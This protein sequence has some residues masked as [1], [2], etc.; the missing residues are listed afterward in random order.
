MLMGRWE[1]I[2]EQSAIAVINAIT[3]ALVG[4]I[5][6]GILQSFIG[7][8]KLD[9][10]SSMLRQEMIDKHNESIRREGE[11][12]A[13]IAELQQ[14]VQARPVQ[15]PQHETKKMEPLEPTVEMPNPAQQRLDFEN[16]HR[17]MYSTANKE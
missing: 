15:P 14:T 6:Y 4:L 17:L 5:G 12:L 1:W 10:M 2:K 16:R 9:R 7:D 3:I 13:K 8:V 11:L